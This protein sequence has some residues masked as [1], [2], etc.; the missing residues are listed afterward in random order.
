M[1]L[2]THSE[3]GRALVTIAVAD[4]AALHGCEF[5]ASGEQ[6]DLRVQLRP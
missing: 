1:K 3:R 4:L 5:P 6:L 2:D